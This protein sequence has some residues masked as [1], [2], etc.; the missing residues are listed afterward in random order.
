MKRFWIISLFIN[1]SCSLGDYEGGPI[2][3]YSTK[4]K[5]NKRFL[6]QHSLLLAQYTWP[7]D[8][9]RM[10]NTI[11]GSPEFG[12]GDGGDV[13]WCVVMLVENVRWVKPTLSIAPSE[14]DGE[15]ADPCFVDDYEISQKL[16]QI[17]FKQRQ[18]L[19][20]ST[21]TSAHSHVIHLLTRGQKDFAT[22]G[23]RVQRSSTKRRQC[24]VIGTPN[25]F[26]LRKRISRY[27]LF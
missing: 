1:L 25:C 16:L 5:R 8:S 3:I 19:L 20:R 18:P 14:M 2:N 13:R 12:R 24:L 22:F 4:E 26:S 10:K 15:S 6:S 7:S 9:T 23:E 11:S 21:H 27:V 17:A